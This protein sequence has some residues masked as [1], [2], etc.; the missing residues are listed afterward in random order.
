VD[1]AEIKQRKT[2]IN[3]GIYQDGKKIRTAS[4]TFMGPAQ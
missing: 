4:S 3:F 2:P 1:P